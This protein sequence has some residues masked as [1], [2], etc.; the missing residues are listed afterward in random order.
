MGK[1]IHRLGLVAG[2]L[3]MAMPG[4]LA[5]GQARDGTVLPY[6]DPVFTGTLGTTPVTSAA[7]Y[8]P[9][10]RLAE[11]APNVLLVMTDD[12]GFSAASTFG[13]AV[14]T[15]NLD[16]LAAR[17][18]RYNRFHVTAMCSPTRAALLTG[19]NH[20]AVATGALSDLAED[21]P[22]YNSRFPKSAASIAKVLKYNGYNTAFFGK[23]HNVPTREQSIA[24]PF[25][26][27][28]IGLGFEYFYGFIGGAI[29][30]F[31]PRLYRGT[32]PVDLTDRPD[33]Y[34]LDRDLA[35]D[36][37]HWIHGQKAAAPDKPFFVYLAPGT[38]HSPLQAPPE[39]I[40][41]FK[42]RFD[43]GWDQMRGDN[44]ARQ[45]TMGIIPADAKLTPRPAEIAAWSSLS[46]EEQQVHARWMEVFCAQ[47]AYQDAQFGRILDE[48]ERMGQLDNTLVIFIEGDNGASLEGGP[49][50]SFN[51]AATMANGVKEPM[52]EKFARIDEIGG[53]NTM[54]KYA[55]GWGWANNTPFRWGKQIASHLGA[56]RDPLV[57]SWPRRITDMGGMRRQY[58]HVTDIYPTI[59]EAADITVPTRVEG[60]E[61]QELGGTSLVYSWDH[62]KAADRHRVQ[63]YEMFA[64]R[65]IYAD[66]WLANTKPRRVAWDFGP[67]AGNPDTSYEW[68]LYHLDSD[69]SQANDLAAERPGKLE[70]MKALFDREARRNNVYPL[71]DNF[72]GRNSNSAEGR[73]QA[74]SEFVYWGQDI[75]L[76][77]KVAPGLGSKD[78]TITIDLAE[79]A[80]VPNGVLVATGS[81]F[82]GWAFYIDDGRPT[83]FVARSEIAPDQSRIAG[84][85]LVP[86]VRQISY[87]Y[88]SRGSDL[89]AGGILTIFADGREVGSGPVAATAALAAG[90]EETFDIGLDSGV[91]VSTDYTKGGKFRGRIEKVA[92]TLASPSGR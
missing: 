79:Q 45:K 53:P 34:V 61:Q 47:L 55:A 7:G 33:D 19:R 41:R 35:D 52:A 16:R 80:D 6:P 70:L 76:S 30:Q 28:P 63:Y 1:R 31:A 43:K 90:F 87:R 91:A 78:F 59:L 10:P 58:S 89:G 60:V 40:A 62:A 37:I 5:R 65:A 49:H 38:A 48:L 66:G 57:I 20:H 11:N 84:N 51:E 24:G 82:G 2:I 86:G 50:S 73:K 85:P 9:R 15:P 64:N 36:A 25:D 18:L 74:R 46:P 81:K 21:Y 83:A 69:F 13:G 56:T 17:G 92:V 88:R 26:Q 71:N 32:L 14:P 72:P 3:A 8:A 68:Q 23:H 75:S 4:S 77:Q 12:V 54:G 67:V 22:G 29:N 39:W 44:F 42:G 27:W